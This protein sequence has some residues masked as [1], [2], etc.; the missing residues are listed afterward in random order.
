MNTQ[1][2]INDYEA[3]PGKININPMLIQKDEDTEY[4]KF[5]GCI[6]QEIERLDFQL[7]ILEKRLS[8]ILPDDRAVSNIADVPEKRNPVSLIRD[9]ISIKDRISRITDEVMYLHEHVVI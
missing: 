6:H 7:S 3:T 8:V 5:Y 1:T 4:M 9:M 2:I